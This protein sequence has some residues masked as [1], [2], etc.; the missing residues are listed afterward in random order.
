[1]PKS[2]LVAA[3]YYALGAREIPTRSP[4]VTKAAQRIVLSLADSLDGIVYVR[5]IS[6]AYMKSRSAQERDVFLV[7]PP[8]I[9]I[10]EGMLL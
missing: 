10:D 4:T 3:N 9:N 8:E 6:Q 7:P 2:G 1:V 5:D